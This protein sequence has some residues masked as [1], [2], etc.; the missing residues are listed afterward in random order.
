MS[1]NPNNPSRRVP[2][3]PEGR[4]HPR[5]TS[6]RTTAQDTP[7]RI[8]TF[9]LR[10][11]RGAITYL[12][13]RVGFKLGKFALAIRH[14][15]VRIKDEN[16]PKGSPEVRCSITVHLDDAGCVIVEHGATT[17]R[18]AFDLTIDRTERAVRRMLQRRRSAWKHSASTR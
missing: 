13:Q 1:P 8:R 17:S 15:D 7:L 12:R 5:N 11:D 3:P 18:A 14:V 16:G 9:G 6:G 4:V 2:F 10:S